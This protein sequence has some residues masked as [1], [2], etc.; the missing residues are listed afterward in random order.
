MRVASLFWLV[1]LVVFLSGSA[2]AGGLL[3]AYGL[4][5]TLKLIV[6][7]FAPGR[8]EHYHP[9]HALALLPLSR[10]LVIAV[11]VAWS[12]FLGLWVVS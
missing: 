11:V 3:G 9:L 10:V 2:I 12:V 7:V 6:G 5:L 4:G 1:S 8:H